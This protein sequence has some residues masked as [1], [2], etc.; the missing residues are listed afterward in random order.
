M[1][2]E[3]WRQSSVAVLVTGASGFLGGRLTQMLLDR[4]EHVVVLARPTSDLRHLPQEAL[5]SGRLL[6][7][8][9]DLG[10]AEALRE[11]VQGVSTV[12]H[13]AACS[14]DWAPLATYEAANVLGTDHL[15][16]AARRAE[17]LQRFVHVSTTDVYGYPE[18]PCAEDH[19]VVDAGLPY[20]RTKSLAEAIVWQARAEHGLPVTVL[21]PAT[22]YGP[23]GKDFTV[24]IATMLRQRM[25]ATVDGGS[26]PGGFVYVDTVAQAMIDAAAVPATEGQAYNIAEGTGIT[27]AEYLKVFSEQLGTK[28]PWIDLPFSAA[29]AVARACELPHRLL[30][31][32]GRPLLTRHAVYLLGR[33]QEFPIEKARAEFGFAPRISIDEGIRRSVAWLKSRA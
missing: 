30:P 17:T 23:R 7:A 22:I 4:G 26:A 10:N 8:R 18:V 33:N 5:A 13:C 21:R 15:V 27:W 9:G 1:S 29:M 6:V 20:N 32:K 16:T 19:P 24:E 12:F 3:S 31:L 14:T 25:M 11:A 28:V 2:F